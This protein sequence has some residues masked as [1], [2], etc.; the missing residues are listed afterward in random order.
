MYTL[1]KIGKIYYA[2]K[3]H[4]REESLKSLKTKNKYIAEKIIRE[5]NEELHREI[6]GLKPKA[7]KNTID[8]CINYFYQYYQKEKGITNSTLDCYRLGIN[9]LKN[10]FIQKRTFND[11][12]RLDYSVLIDYLYTQGYNPTT[13]NIRLRG[14]RTFLNYIKEIEL[15]PELPFK[16]KQ[17]KVEKKLPQFITPEEIEKIF[18]V[19]DDEKHLATF[20][21]LLITGM[22][23]GELRDS[24]RDKN[25][26]KVTT[27]KSKSE[28]IIPISDEY[29]ADYD[30][31]TSPTLES[32]YISKS[33]RKYADSVGINDKTLHSLR[34]TF[35]LKTLMETNN[36]YYVKNQLGHTSVTTTEIY[37][38]FPENYIKQIFKEKG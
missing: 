38:K 13:I 27:S 16:I 20:K 9:D 6:L 12:K 8:G 34:H 30:L 36:I 25:F 32:G 23:V 19:V 7:N 22:R 10:A 1:K 21:T 11:L 14:I 5:L 3:R 35:A 18:S 4:L 26:I 28:R 33:F 31:A 24:I 37:L 17:I 29:I 15:I 2:R